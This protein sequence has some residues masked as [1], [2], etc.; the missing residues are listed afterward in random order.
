V[1]GWRGR[2]VRPTLARVGPAPSS[3]EAALTTLAA[4]ALTLEVTRAFARAGVE[5][6][7]LKGASIADVLYDGTLRPYDD[8]D[9]LVDPATR[10]AAESVLYELGFSPPVPSHVLV[11]PHATAWSHPRR[12]NRVDLHQTLPGVK[13]SPEALWRALGPEVSTVDLAGRHVTAL[14]RGALAFHIALHAAQHGPARA[15]ALADLRRAIERLGPGDWR[16]AAALARELNAAEA[17]VTG[18]CL[19]PAGGA[20]V[21]RLKLEGNPSRETAL[22][23]ISA[24]SAAITLARLTSTRGLRGKLAGLGTIALPPADGVRSQTRLARR[25]G[26]GLALA[27]ALRLLRHASDVV[28]VAR[29]W[30]TAG[31]SVGKR[32]R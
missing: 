21:K 29:A 2:L 32:T 20:V 27:Y 7:L 26:Y 6:I 1:P 19:V 12:P 11:E 18:L 8:V 30:W 14:G 23:A 31:R 4:D 25:G 28:P 10:L 13:E 17:F 9:L 5:S 22:M 15:K 24:P 3:R 16:R